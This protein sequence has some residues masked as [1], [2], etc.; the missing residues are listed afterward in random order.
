MPGCGKSTLGVILAKAINYDFLDSDL[1]IQKKMGIKL[2]EIINQYG[3]D[4]F[5]EI[6]EEVNA[7]IDVKDTVIATG[8]SVVYGE[9]AMEHLKSISTVIYLRLSVNEILKRVDNM[10]TRGISMKPG[11]TLVDLYNKRVPLYEKYADIVVDCNDMNTS[12][13]LGAILEALGNN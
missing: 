10:R 12:Q 2:Q 4:R 11:E 5:R 8:G 13:A 1:L 3:N 9:K 6:E 7:S